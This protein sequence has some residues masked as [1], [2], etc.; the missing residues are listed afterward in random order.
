MANAT[1]DPVEANFEVAGIE[2]PR[3]R[4]WLWRPWY[5]K[6]WWACIACYWVGKLALYWYRPLGDFYS[7]AFAGYANIAF[8]PFTALLVLGAR[9]IPVWMSCRGWEWRTPSHDELASKRSTGVLRDPYSDPLDP[10]CPR[11]WR[12]HNHH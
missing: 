8:Y 12:R 3:A 6:L 1:D 11:Y 9:F 5:A 7:T 4:S 10:R 2:H